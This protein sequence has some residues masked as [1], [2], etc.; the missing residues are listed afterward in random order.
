MALVSIIIP[1]FGKKSFI[2]KT[3][4]S[5]LNQTFQDF[6]IILIYDDENKDD[7]AYIKKILNENSKV[8]IIDNKRNLGA[9]LSRNLGIKKSSGS[10]I[11]F[12][13]A[14]DYWVPERLEKQINFMM[15]KNYKFTF[16]NY[17]KKNGKEIN[18]FSKKSKVSYKDLLTDC[19]I[20]LSTV[21]LNKSIIENDLFPPLKTKE[22]YVA[23]LKV[24]KN[25]TFAHNFPEYL[26]EW[27]YAKDQLSSNF[28]QKII[29]GFRVYFIY[30]K[31]SFLKSMFYL[32]VL[33]FN[34]IKR[35]F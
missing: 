29:D 27:N 6:E 33:G 14:D 10:I 30:L 11:A 20:G 12:L 4:T 1:Y 32:L 16:C 18:V 26:V 9:G 13:D 17:K 35:K 31:L 23:W 24:T 2:Q 5:V 25:N 3:L 28:F 34:S 21:L 19:E 22:D 8:K 15:E 7:L